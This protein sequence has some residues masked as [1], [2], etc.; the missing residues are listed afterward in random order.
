MLD[1]NLIYQ[2]LQAIA[3][4][5]GALIFVWVFNWLSLRAVLGRTEEKKRIMHNLQRFVQIVVF[6]IS[7]V[8]VLNIFDVD[9]TGLLAGLG[10][11]ALVIGYALK[12]VI[13]AWVSGLLII[14]GKT[15]RIGDVIM[16]GN[17]KGV[18][19]DISL[20]TTKLR[21]YDQNEVVI[22]NSSLLREKIINL[23]HG[24][25]ETVVSITFS[26]DYVFNPEKAKNA[27]EKCLRRHPNVIIN[28]DKK[29]EIRFVIRNKE[30]ITEIETLFWINT[31]ENEEF[32]KSQI[33]ESVRE[34][35]DK[36]KILPPL[37]SLIRKEY[38]QNIQ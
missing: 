23:T 3:V 29:R 1:W 6:A 15:F 10:I 11:G 25:K 17:L 13:E 32:I 7:L 21:T 34:E 5:V 30:W 12:D 18:V 27:I 31:A 22:P 38:L 33:S 16:V 4:G 8:L 20:R 24:K 37:P 35:F 36:E 19:T 14:S 28:K 26:I 2:I 9:V